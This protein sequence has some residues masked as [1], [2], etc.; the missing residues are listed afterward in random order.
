MK[1]FF[2]AVLCLMLC[3]CCLPA[4]A[5]TLTPFGSVCELYTY[6]DYAYFQI[7]D[8]YE[9]NDGYPLYISEGHG[10]GDYVAYTSA[11]GAFDVVFLPDASGNSIA[12]IQMLGSRDM[13]MSGDS[14]ALI[15]LMYH[16]VMGLVYP[17]IMEEAASPNSGT[18]G[19]ALS[20]AIIDVV[21][22]AA[23]GSS[24]YASDTIRFGDVMSISVFLQDGTIGVQ[25]YFD[26][27]VTEPM[28][29]ERIYLVAAALSGEE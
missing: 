25:L 14:D 21:A 29:T 13:F 1:R 20:E 24:F 26:E 5:E 8:V 6:F 19:D 18:F 15:Q 9:F 7:I 28:L 2:A 16:R 27:P 10:Y 23:T 11:G 17:F 4:G 22:Q 3:L 12:E